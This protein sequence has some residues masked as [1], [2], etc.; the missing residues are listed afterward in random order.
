[1][2]VFDEL[3]ISHFTK[4]YI[5]CVD[6]M[7]SRQITSRENWGLVF[8]LEGSIHYTINGQRYSLASGGALL[9]PKG[10]TYRW[11]STYGR[12]PVIDF[13]CT[14]LNVDTIMPFQTDDPE[15]CLREFHRL[16]NLTLFPGTRLEQLSVFYGLLHKLSQASSPHYGIL[17]PVLDYLNTHLMDPSLTNAVLAEKASISEIYLRKLFSARLGT[18]PRQYILNARIEKAKQLLIDTHQAVSNTAEQCGFSS[19]Y[20]FSR[21]FRQKTGMTPTQY[22]QKNRVDQL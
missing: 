14:N 22:A 12:F 9:L 13:E 20:H 1:M 19:L 5:C 10:G 2:N 6:R 7:R 3:I 17:T 18:T 16:Q 4:F 8:C 15:F 11:V 21:C